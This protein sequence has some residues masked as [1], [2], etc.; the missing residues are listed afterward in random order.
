VCKEEGVRRKERKRNMG[1]QSSFSERKA[2]KNQASKHTQEDSLIFY[3]LNQ[4]FQGR[5][6]HLRAEV[7]LKIE[8]RG[9]SRGKGL[10]EY[11]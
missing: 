11:P 8:N 6:F 1:P 4:H 5:P 9:Q 3:F 2:Q 7:S 10:L